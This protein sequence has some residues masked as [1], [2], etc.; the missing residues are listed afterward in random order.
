MSKDTPEG[1]R[2]AKVIARAGRASRREAERLIEAGRV[3]VNGAQV[4][5]AALNVTP[6]DR[7]TVDGTPLEAPDA[8]RLWL[9]HKPTGLV[10]TTRD[11]QGRPTIYDE[12][13][14]DLPRVMSV[15]RLD[16]N[17]EGLLLLTNDGGVKRKLELPST[18]WLRK[19]RVRVK[20]RPTDAMLAPLRDGLE[21]DGM[22]FQPMTVA[23][24]RQQGANAWLTVGLREGKNREIRRAMS[25]IGL[26]VNRLIRLSYGPFQ[27]GQLKPG[28]VQEVRRKILRD[29]LGLPAPETEGTATA[30]KRPVRRRRSP[31]GRGRS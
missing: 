24:D 23:L 17:S 11:E 18:G 15:G 20:G 25:D 30:R 26:E 9:Y 22:R 19:Y 28:E 31:P 5:R 13:P 29:Q 16:L 6:S 21:V 10:T 14:D 8:A 4:E 27:L 7:I 12:L 3:T 2:I 1:E